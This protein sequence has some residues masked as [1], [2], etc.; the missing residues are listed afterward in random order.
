MRTAWFSKI[1][2]E[3]EGLEADIYDSLHEV[4]SDSLGGYFPPL[5]WSLPVSYNAKGVSG[6]AAGPSPTGSP[7]KLR[8]SLCLLETQRC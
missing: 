6:P 7:G 1:R 4:G 5:Q 2:S 8:L 3:P